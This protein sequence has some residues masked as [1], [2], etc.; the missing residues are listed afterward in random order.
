LEPERVAEQLG[1]DPSDQL[2]GFN[3]IVFFEGVDDCDFFE[4]VSTALYAAGKLPSTFQ[5]K[6]IGLLHGGGDD[7]KHWVNRRNIKKLN[8]KFTVVLDSDRT[9][10]DCLVPQKKIAIKAS[11]ENDGGV[12]HILRKREIENYIHPETLL[13]KTGKNIQGDGCEFWDMKK[14]AGPGIAGLIKHMT[15]D[16]IAFMDRYIVGGV[17]KNEL[18]EICQQILTMVP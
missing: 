14:L 10:R 17:E 15:A 4:S 6:N 3:A 12:C 2:F 16:E 11:V 8:R 9:S 5:A 18:H 7:L 1:I 13:Q